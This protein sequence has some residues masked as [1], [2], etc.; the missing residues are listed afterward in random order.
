MK[1]YIYVE[2][3]TSLVTSMASYPDDFFN[4]LSVHPDY[5]CIELPEPLPAERISDLYYKN[6]KLKLK[7]APPSEFHKW[8]VETELYEEDMEKAK[9]KYIAELRIA[10]RQGEQGLKTFYKNVWYNA[11]PQS[12]TDLVS[13]ILTEAF[14][15]GWRTLE[16]TTQ[17]L[18]MDEAKELLNK[19]R[20]TRLAF[21][22]QYWRLK[23]EVNAAPTLDTLPTHRIEQFVNLY[24][25]R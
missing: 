1:T 2:K 18:S 6:E 7:P 16:N 19:V 22:E 10:E 21:R 25:K 23:D 4:P 13:A 20:A 17:Y 9:E 12:E 8:N 11:S 15:Q 5:Y 24:R 14:P 3:K